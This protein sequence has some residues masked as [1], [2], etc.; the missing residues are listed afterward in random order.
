[1]MFIEECGEAMQAISKCERGIGTEDAVLEELVDV[2]IA[3]YSL[4][5][6]YGNSKEFG[7]VMKRKLDRLEGKLDDLE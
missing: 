7:K 4:I 2:H 3:L 6:V 5:D 1:M